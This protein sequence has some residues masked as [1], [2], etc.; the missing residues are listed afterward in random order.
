MN[1]KFELVEST[2]QVLQEGF[3]W[4][5]RIRSCWSICYLFEVHYG[6]S[7]REGGAVT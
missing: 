2:C 5:L 6:N 7:I 4:L 3:L 1:S